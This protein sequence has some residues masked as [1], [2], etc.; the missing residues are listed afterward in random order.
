VKGK[1]KVSHLFYTDDLKLFSRDEF[2]VQQDLIIVKTF[3]D[4]IRTELSLDKYATA[5]LSMAR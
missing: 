1:Y 2:E 3:S 4:N 5:N